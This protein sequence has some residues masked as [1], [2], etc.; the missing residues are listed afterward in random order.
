M[1]MDMRYLHVFGISAVM[2]AVLI[3]AAREA[4]AE[5]RPAGGVPRNHLP[6][7]NH[8]SWEG[9]HDRFRGDRFHGGFTGFWVEDRDPVV[10]EREVV[11]EV[12][13]AVPAPE[14]APP[15][16]EAYVIG[17]TYA[18]LPG[19]CMKLIEEGVSFYYCGGEWY[20]QVGEGRSVMYKAVAR[21]L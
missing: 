3:L 13:V 9:G 5:D 6:S 17:K 8:F 18:S 10:I 14:P 2:S 16:R 19:G 1:M 21:K 7:T 15:P 20:Q 11:H 4:G 12:P